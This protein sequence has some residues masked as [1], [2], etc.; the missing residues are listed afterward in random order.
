MESCLPFRHGGMDVCAPTFK[1]RC[2]QEFRKKVTPHT[3]T[4][5]SS[6]A[7]KGMKA[8]AFS[9][10]ED[11]HPPLGCVPLPIIA[12]PESSTKVTLRGSCILLLC[13]FSGTESFPPGNASSGTR[14]SRV[15]ARRRQDQRHD[16]GF[17]GLDSP[18]SP[19]GPARAP[20]D[21]IR[22]YLC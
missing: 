9:L 12:I 1:H 14:G 20:L 16:L 2:H 19:G 15:S 11:T 22:E 13:T 8:Q 4:F 17:Q 5:L 21:S 10:K 7:F 18:H 3:P 6:L